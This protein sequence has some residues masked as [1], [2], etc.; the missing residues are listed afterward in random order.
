MPHKCVGAHL[1]ICFIFQVDQLHTVYV[2]VRM[3]VVGCPLG[4]QLTAKEPGKM[5]IVRYYPN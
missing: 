2:P 5:P 3:T 4:F 1:S